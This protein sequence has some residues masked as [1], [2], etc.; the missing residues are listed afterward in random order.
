M[1]PITNQVLFLPVYLQ[2]LSYTLGINNIINY[3]NTYTVASPGNIASSSSFDV[4]NSSGSNKPAIY[5]QLRYFTQGQ[6]INCLR[7][8]AINF[9]CNT[10]SRCFYSHFNSTVGCCKLNSLPLLSEN[11]TNCMRYD[12]PS[13]FSRT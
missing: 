11:L 12:S 2:T 8:L 5:Y 1:F 10:R 3:F 7:F 13:I 9:Y 4:N 6:L